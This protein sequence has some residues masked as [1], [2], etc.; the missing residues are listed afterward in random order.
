MKM[1]VILF[2]HEPSVSA[3]GQ[4]TFRQMGLRYNTLLFS[5]LKLEISLA[6]KKISSDVFI[7]NTLYLLISNQTESSILMVLGNPF[8]CKAKYV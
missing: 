3:V 7:D 1:E 8:P 6:G 4:L 5:P 2:S